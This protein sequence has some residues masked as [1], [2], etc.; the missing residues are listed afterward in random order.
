MLRLPPPPPLLL[1]AEMRAAEAAAIA[2]GTPALQL[3]ERASAA[4]AAAVMAVLPKRRALVLAGPGNNGG[5]GYGVALRLRDMGVEVQVAALSPPRGEPAQTMAAQWDEPVLPLTAATPAPLVIDALFGTGLDRSMPNEACAA[6]ARLASGGVVAALDIVSNIDAATGA[7]LGPV[8]PAALTIA[9]GA[10]K[11]GHLL[12]AGA[13]TSGRLVTADI[14][15]ALPDVLLG[16]VVRPVRVPLPLGTHKYS[17]GALLVVEGGEGQGGAARLAALAALRVGAGLVTLIGPEGRLPADAI[18]HRGDEE[19][20]ALLADPRVGA[21]VIG[22]GLAEG[23]RGRE[24]LAR[25]LGERVP[26]VLDAGAL[27]LLTPE[28]LRAATAPLVLTPHEGEFRALFG[29]IGADRLAAVRAAANAAQ[30]VVLLK[31]AQTLIAAPGGRVL[32]NDHAS[33]WLATA[34][35]GDVLAGV[36]ASLIAQGMAGFEA[37]AAAAWVHGEAGR[38]GGSGLIADDLPSLVGAVL[39]DL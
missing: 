36:I 29:P 3:M 20:A 8:V 5:D 38:R 35:S 10:A 28:R 16:R 14:G 13:T 33:P 21:V 24:W 18:M 39:A 32:I 22:P 30:A 4:A 27:A 1:P 26:L 11:P 6:L 19:G 9:F 7:A 25:L 2:A 15:I 12:G 37:A 23:T 31:G 17:R 34:G